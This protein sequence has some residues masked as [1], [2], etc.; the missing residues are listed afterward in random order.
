MQAVAEMLTRLKSLG[1]T[2]ES[3]NMTPAQWAQKQVD[4]YNAKEGTLNE[5]DD[6]S[7][8]L[9]KNKGDIAV[10]NEYPAGCFGMKYRDCRCMNTRRSIERMRQSGLKNIIKDY[11]LD[12]YEAT[13]PWQKAIKDAAADYAKEPKGWFFVGGQTGAGKTHI[14]TAICRELLIKGRSVVYMVWRDDIARLK[15]LA[16][17]ADQRQRMIDRFKTAEVLYVDDLFKTGRGYDGEAQKPTGADINVAFEILNYRYNNPGLLTVISSE[18]T[19][20]DILQID[21]ATGGRIYERAVVFNLAADQKRNY[22]LRKAR[23]CQ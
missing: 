16:M 22:R 1:V 18:S 10:L 9:C 15:S 5:Q 8:S 21:E 20:D 23:E 11:T 3:E 17:E 7:C 14:C 12:K 4:D 19:I 2:F 6:Y 13:E